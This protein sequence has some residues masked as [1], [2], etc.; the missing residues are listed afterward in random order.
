MTGEQLISCALDIGEGMLTS[1]AEVGIIGVTT[2][3]RI[4]HTFLV[5]KKQ[6]T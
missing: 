4:L 2:L 3:S 1:G 5:H 6:R